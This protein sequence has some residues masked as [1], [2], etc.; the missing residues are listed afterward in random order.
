MS[1]FL[2]IYSRVS[3]TVFAT[4]RRR[5]CKVE[6]GLS[7]IGVWLSF[8]LPASV[9]AFSNNTKHKLG[10][11]SL[12]EYGTYNGVYWK[13]TVTPYY[14]DDPAGLFWDIMTGGTST[15]YA[16]PN[17]RRRVNSE[18]NYN[19]I[20]P[21]PG[22]SEKHWNLFDMVF[23]FGHNNMITPPHECENEPALVQQQRPDP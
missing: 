15:E 21:I 12:Y 18:V 3:F 13:G 6:S 1:C 7:D 19:T 8:L 9:G 17:S 11:Y 14:N 4:L 16:H 20:F 23:F 22:S 2:V 10:A 5:L